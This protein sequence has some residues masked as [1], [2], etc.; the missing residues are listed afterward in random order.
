[1]YTLCCYDLA[2]LVALDESAAS[3]AV[4]LAPL[5][6]G[7]VRTRDLLATIGEDYPVA[8]CEARA[9]E[10]WRRLLLT[11]QRCAHG[12]TCFWHCWARYHAVFAAAWEQEL[13]RGRRA[14]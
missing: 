2:A 7:E 6:P 10:G 5:Y 12:A 1:M 14:A 13:A 4:M 3:L 9:A 11:W 8:T